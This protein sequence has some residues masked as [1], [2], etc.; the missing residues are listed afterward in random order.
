MFYELATHI[1]L[2]KGNKNAD[3]KAGRSE[4]TERT[5]LDETDGFGIFM[6]SRCFQ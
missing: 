5:G 1:I 6:Q 4:N 2:I 3:T